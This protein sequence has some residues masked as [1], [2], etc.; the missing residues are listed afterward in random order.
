MNGFTH[1]DQ[2]V[3][4]YAELSSS[5]ASPGS[6]SLVSGGGHR[7][8]P[9]CDRPGC[10]SKVWRE[11]YAK[12]NGDFLGWFCVVCDK[13]WRVETVPVRGGLIQCA[14]RGQSADTRQVELTT[15]AALLNKLDEWELRIWQLAL[16]G[17]L[18]KNGM[19]TDTDADG[20]PRHRYEAVAIAAKRLWSAFSPA[21]HWHVRTL[22]SRARD[23]TEQI[24]RDKELL[25]V[26]D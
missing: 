8:E 11:R 7:F 25:R 9:R 18:T 15:L 24:L 4:R 16:L 20:R 10:T 2:V 17:D 19:N 26:V 14:A 1:P 22:I 6:V 3:Y 21:T 5:C 13:P 12:R 23:T